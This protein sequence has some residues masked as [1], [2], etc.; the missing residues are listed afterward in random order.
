MTE[1][2]FYSTMCLFVGLLVKILNIKLK[3]CDVGAKF[4]CG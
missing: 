2:Q 1:L 4:G 3:P